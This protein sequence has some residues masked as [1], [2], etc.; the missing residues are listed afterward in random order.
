VL[1]VIRELFF[2][3]DKGE[4]VEAALRI[5]K[6]EAKEQHAAVEK[7]NGPVCVERKITVKKVMAF[8]LTID[9]I[10]CGLSFR[11]ASNILTHTASRTGLHMLRGVR[12]EE[13][14]ARFVRA[15]VGIKY[16]QYFVPP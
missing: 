11:Q 2:D 3:P 1:N 14:V 12:E 16:G 9:Y 10:S 4:R 6:E 7:G 8:N 13:E 5:F 15:V